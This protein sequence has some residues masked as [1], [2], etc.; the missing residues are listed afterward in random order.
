MSKSRALAGLRVG[1]ALGDRGLIEALNRVKDSF[2][3][4]PLGRGRAGRRDG[5]GAR[6]RLFPRDP[7]A[8]R[9]RPRSDDART[10]AA[11]LLCFAVQRQF[12]L[13][14]APGT[15]WRR[16]RGGAARTGGAGAAFQ[17]AAHGV[18]SAHHGRDGRRYASADRGG[19]RDPGQEAVVDRRNEA[20]MSDQDKDAAD[21]RAYCAHPV[22]VA[23]FRPTR[24]RCFRCS[25]TTAAGFSV[26]LRNEAGTVEVHILGFPSERG[27]LQKYRADP[28]R[29]AAAPKSVGNIRATLLRDVS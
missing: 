17:Q 5:L 9:R 29:E 21:A 12:R 2:N 13:R 7:R 16:A 1:Y 28:R 19:R 11:R 27:S 4:Y 8:D 10:D 24:I 20:G 26:R 25:A 23:R 22:R 6:R 14:R 15:G 18:L 3:S